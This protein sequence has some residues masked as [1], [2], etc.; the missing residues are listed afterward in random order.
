MIATTVGNGRSSKRHSIRLVSSTP[1]VT[2]AS[3]A[4]NMPPNSV[5]SA[6][7]MNTDL[8]EVRIRPFTSGALAIAW[9]AASRSLSATWLSLLTDSPAR[10]NFSSTMPSPSAAAL[11]AGPEYSMERSPNVQVQ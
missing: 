8:P 11:K 7:T 4:A 5:M 9:V 10:S 1:A 3:P 2:A 6:P